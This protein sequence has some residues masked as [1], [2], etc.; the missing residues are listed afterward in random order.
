MSL[1]HVQ[2]LKNKSS[3]LE[4]QNKRLIIELKNLKEHVKS[5]EREILIL[6]EILAEYG[7]RLH[8]KVDEKI[9]TLCHQCR[10]IDQQKRG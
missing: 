3:F 9:R 10:E 4:E 8:E 6:A 1:E 2:F 7:F 5:I